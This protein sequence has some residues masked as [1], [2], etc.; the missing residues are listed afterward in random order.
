MQVLF[1][2]KRFFENNSVKNNDSVYVCLR[3]YNFVYG[4]STRQNEKDNFPIIHE[5]R[6]P[7]FVTLK[8]RTFA[9]Y[10]N[11]FWSP[12]SPLHFANNIC[13]L[14]RITLIH[15]N[16]KFFLVLRPSDH[17]AFLYISIQAC[18]S[19]YCMHFPRTTSIYTTPMLTSSGK[20][21]IRGQVQ[22]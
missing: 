13:L 19:L 3:I 5:P 7:V 6:H 12:D 15:L 14:Y 21:C 4:L 18:L 2:R 9:D 1:V 11:K 17:C 10:F 16:S 22:S 20:C 8:T